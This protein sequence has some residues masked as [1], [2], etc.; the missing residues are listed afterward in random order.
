MNADGSGQIKV[1]LGTN[2]DIYLAR[3]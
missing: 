2:P 1:D 3:G